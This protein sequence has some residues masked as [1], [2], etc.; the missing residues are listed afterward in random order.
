[1]NSHSPTE[2]AA[3]QGKTRG[4]GSREDRIEHHVHKLRIVK[5]HVC[6]LRLSLP[7]DEVGTTILPTV[8]LGVKNPPANAGEMQD[9]SLGREDPLEEGMATRSSILAW[10]ILWT[11]EPGGLQS[12]GSQSRTRLKRLSSSS[13]GKGVTLGLLHGSCSS[14]VISSHLPRI[15]MYV[16]QGF[17]SFQCLS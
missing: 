8:A 9:R 13:Q 7:L 6:C 11:E 5:R 10:R 4:P 15:Q 14:Q 12:M 17:L 3:V 2:P 16:F 1:M